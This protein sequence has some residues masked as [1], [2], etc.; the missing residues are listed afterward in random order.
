MAPK[1]NPLKLNPLQLKTLTL[2]Q[3]IAEIAGEP[4]ADGRVRLHQLP[5]PHGNHFHIGAAVVSGADA[6]G[7]HN[8]AVWVALGRKGLVE[9]GMTLT[10]AGLA[11]D[12]GLRDKILHRADH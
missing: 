12:T 10:P 5:S 11:Y 6:T 1:L 3:A 4:L 8:E 2:L 9:P 7:L